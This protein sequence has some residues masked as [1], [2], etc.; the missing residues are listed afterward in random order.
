MSYR[1]LGTVGLGALY[2]SR[3]LLS[4]V[5]AQLLLVCL[6]IIKSRAPRTVRVYVVLCF[7]YFLAVIL[8]HPSV[9][10]VRHMLFFFSF[11]P[12]FLVML[13]ARN[14]LHNFA[15][16]P[17]FIVAVCVITVAEAIALNSPLSGYLWF[18]PEDH[19]YRTLFNGFYQR[20]SG[21]AGVASSSG[22]LV[23]FS[24]VL[25]DAGQPRWTVL[26]KQMVAAVVT[27]IVLASGTGFVLFVL[28]LA[29]RAAIR[30]KRRVSQMSR[31]S[32]FGLVSLLA[33]GSVGV[34]AANGLTHFSLDYVSAIYDNKAAAV[35]A[36]AA[37][38]MRGDELLLGHQI[39]GSEPALTT[40]GDFGYMSM[41]S[42][43]GLLGTMLVVGTPLLF[44][45]SLHA[46]AV[47]SILFLLSFVHYPA[48]SSPPG[49]LLFALYLQMLAMHDR[50]HRSRRRTPVSGSDPAAFPG[51]LGH[52]ASP[53]GATSS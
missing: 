33:F 32:A 24:L 40:S 52:A 21:V 1:R 34:F 3:Y 15:V 20:P 46:F 16:T 22:A 19:A 45:G 8:V 28:Y 27:L 13:S 25:C 5:P 4:T 12:P 10:A 26:S 41:V 42:S 30:A 2:F 47:P 35:R 14:S 51:T 23:V 49:A 31:L 53:A 11:V 38:D 7:I 43:I 39:S 37:E 36:W 6:L 29:L 50:T 9:T 44:A 18:F 48:L 17:S